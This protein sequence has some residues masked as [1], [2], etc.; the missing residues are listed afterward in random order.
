MIWMNKRKIMKKAGGIVLG[1]I[2]VTAVFISVLLYRELEECIYASEVSRCQLESLQKEV[3]IAASGLPKGIVLTEENVSYGIIYSD[4]PMENFITEECFGM[5]LLVDVE[6]G[7]RLLKE[8]L[9]EVSENTRSVFFSE[10]EIAEHIQTGDRVDV[11]IR[12]NNA[13][14]YIVL[15]DKILVR[16]ESGK[17]MILE[18]TEE[19]ILLISSAISD[20]TRYKGTKLYVVEYPEHKLMEEGSSNYIA[21][22]EVLILLKRENKEGESRIAL[23]QRLERTE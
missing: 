18:L 21:N 15:S 13:E 22:T 1:L 17:G 19:E 20:C 3:Y 2:T 7:T 4:E 11:R 10:A 14:D 5:K 16:S 12:Y 6:A 8:M 23:E 9:Q